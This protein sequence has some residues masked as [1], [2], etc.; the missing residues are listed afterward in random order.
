MILRQALD[1]AFERVDAGRCKHSGLAHAAADHFAPAPCFGDEL[2]RCAEYRTD[3][4][5]ESL[6]Q[7]H[8][9]GIEIPADVGDRHLQM[10]GCVEYARAVQMQAESAGAREF[11]RPFQ[12]VE[13][14]HLAA[15]RILQAE[16]PRP[17]KMRIVRLDRG[18]DAREIERT[19]RFVVE[20]LRLDAA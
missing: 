12:V 15:L 4:C 5:A 8:R 17:G 14:Q 19:I 9:H 13:R 2:L 6:G 10:H 11:L 1:V 7:T 18:F 20:R 3:R 16:Q